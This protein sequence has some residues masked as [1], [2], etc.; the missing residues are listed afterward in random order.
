MQ[1]PS[2]LNAIIKQNHSGLPTADFLKQV[3]KQYPYFIPAQFYLLQQLQE[4]DT[5]YNLQA[6]KTAALFNNPHWLRF[7]LHNKMVD[8]A[9][10]TEI[11]LTT[12]L[13]AENSDNDDDIVELPVPEQEP[14]A[15]A[16]NTNSR[17]EPVA[18][19]QRSAA[20]QLMLSENADNDDDDI[21]EEEIAPIKITIQAPASTGKEEALT[22][23]PMHLVDYFASQGIKLS[24]E[25]QTADKLGKQLKS[26]T[27][28]LKTMKKIHTPETE[29]NAGI[30]DMVIQTLAAK[31]NTEGEI[32][33]E[34]M[35]E[36]L[37]QQGKAGKAIEVYKKLSLLN[38]AKR[39]FFAAKIEQLKG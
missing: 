2:L 3:T 38:P 7:Q 26:F 16:E 10:T 13:P 30:A 37:M 33:T 6:A 12:I 36:V 11:A 31:S 32:V 24:D 15:I 4:T 17:N 9:L 35:A 18:E 8:A 19:L 21:M 28:W 14:T 1:Q 27:D 22:F 34:A 5:A 25:V 20:E 39:A 29:A 23:E